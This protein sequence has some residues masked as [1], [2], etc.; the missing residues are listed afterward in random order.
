MDKIIGYSRFD[1]RTQPPNQSPEYGS[2][3]LRSPSQPPLR[4]PH[5]LTETSAPLFTPARYPETADLT[6]YADGR[7][8]AMGERIIVAGRV[9][10]EEG[11]P[12]PHAMVEVWQANAAGRYNHEGDQHDAPLDPDFRGNG[13]VFTDADGWY[14]YVTIKPGAYPWRNHHNAWR[15][16]H[17][18]YSLF[19]A[20]FA[21]RLITQMYFPGD[22]LLPIDPIFNTVPDAAARDR[23][24]AKFD[25]D[26]TE[27]EQAL[28]YRF[29]VV[30]R[31]RDATP[32]EDHH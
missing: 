31:G 24:I 27:P 11:R 16:N 25:L 9:L 3:R 7:G 28:G 12:V 1:P 10:D 26:I 6:T 17:I 30:L 21:Q 29:D 18:H 22:P 14:R 20:G 23:L 32:M 5:G 2:T 15:P 13:R 8:H 4:V 19:G